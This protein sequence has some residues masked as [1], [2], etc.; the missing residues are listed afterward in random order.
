MNRMIFDGPPRYLNVVEGNR[1]IG[2]F[3]VILVSL[4]RDQDHIARLTVAADA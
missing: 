2:K 4:A 3:L 1:V